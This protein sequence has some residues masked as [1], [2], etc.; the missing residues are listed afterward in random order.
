MGDFC[1]GNSSSFPLS[2][3]NHGIHLPFSNFSI[4]G[5]PARWGRYP[6]GVPF[7]RPKG[8]KTR[9]GRSPL[10]TSL[11]YEAGP[12]SRLYSARHLCCGSWYCHH[13]R[14][15][16][17]AGPMARQFPRPGLPWHS[18]VPA[19]GSQT[20]GACQIPASIEIR[21]AMRHTLLLHSSLLPIPCPL[22]FP[23]TSPSPR[24]FSPGSPG[25][26]R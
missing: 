25:C 17:A 5:L 6:L 16:W 12:A 10:R 2:S 1:Q 24:V 22:S 9:L 7:V 20:P 4:A 8:T 14:P 19:A 23:G 15:P 26:I 11:G 21:A 3:G 18:G 13:T